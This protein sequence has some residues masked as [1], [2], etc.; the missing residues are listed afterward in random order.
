MA[1]QYFYD[2]QIRRYIQ[3]FIRLFSGFSVQMGKNENN[4]SIY[5]QVPVRYGDINRMAAHITRENSENV[6]NTVPF[7]SCYVT[8]LDMLSERR[9]YQDHVDKVQ[10]N[11]KKYDQ[12]TGEYT[13]E[14][15]NQYTIERHAP[16]PYKLIMNCDIW[17]SNTDQKLQLMEQILVLFNPTLDIRT[18][19]SPVDWTA[20]SMVE[21]TNTTWSTRS[22]GSSID[23][24]ID[25]ATLTFDIPIY[26]TPP[27]KVKQQKLIH[28]IINELYSLDDDDLDSFKSNESFNTETLKYTIVTYEDKKVKYENDTMQLLNNQGSNLDT[29]G[30]ILSW[31]KEL[32]PFGTL[33]DG[34]SQVRLRKG[35]DPSDND[36]D[37]VGRLEAH[38][39]DPNLLNV[40]IDTATL[41]TNTLQPIDGVV[42]PSKNY[43]GD[44]SVPSVVSGQRYVVL[45]DCPVSAQWTNVVANKNDIIEYNGSSW[46][47]SFDSSTINDTQYVTNVS[48]DD[49]LEWN[50]T[51]W[52]NSYEG[53]YNSGYWRIYL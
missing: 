46:V 25:V 1:Q 15:G 52:I 10:V 8:S 30:E 2:K 26:I 42:D 11:E 34:I 23:D 49:Q 33:R 38:P 16:V 41:R 21:L 39:S 7:I 13:N 19:S 36:D 35:A 3:Q 47:V 40:T 5:Q 32:T 14:L 9:T 17:T 28:T 44:G 12:T 29:N 48:S 37:I 50:G 31:S 43:P 4:L 22:V 27:A 24:I 18:N 53:I 20:L 51:D 6:M 45:N